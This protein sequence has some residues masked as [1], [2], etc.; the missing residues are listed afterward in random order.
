MCVNVIS[1]LVDWCVCNDT[2]FG[3]FFVF[4]CCLFFFVFFLSFFFLVYVI[5]IIIFILNKLSSANITCAY[6][7]ERQ[8]QAMLACGL[9]NIIYLIEGEANQMRVRAFRYIISF[10]Y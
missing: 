6:R 3:M 7:Y 5:I 1:V 8:K 9:S 10:I 2:V 4:F